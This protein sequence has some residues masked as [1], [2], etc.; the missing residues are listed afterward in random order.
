MQRSPRCPR[1]ASA[2]A[3]P[4]NSLGEA[5]TPSPPGLGAQGMFSAGSTPDDKA[6]RLFWLTREGTPLVFGQEIYKSVDTT[7]RAA[8]A[9]PWGDSSTLVV[10]IERTGASSPY[11]YLVR[12]QR[13]ACKLD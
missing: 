13:M 8:A 10:W 1:R 12:G 6:V 9:A 4:I 3:L 11:Q 2:A 7:V 5:V